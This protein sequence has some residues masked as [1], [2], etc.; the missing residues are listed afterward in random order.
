MPGRS[1]IALPVLSV[2]W[3]LIGAGAPVGGLASGTFTNPLLDG[4]ADPWVTYDRGY[5]YYT[6]TMGDRLQIWKTKDITQLRSAVTKVVWRAPATGPNSASIWAPELHHLGGKWYLYF[7]GADRAHDDD[8]HRHQFVLENSATDPL[9]GRWVE[10]G[11]LV[12]AHTGIDGTVFSDHGQLYFVYSAYIGPNSDLIIA[13]MLN[14][15][16]LSKTQIDIAQ[17]TFAWEEQGGR[18]ILEGPEF[19]PGRHGQRIL[20]Y[21]ASA[22]WSDDYS[23]GMLIAAP[24]K[25]LL[26]AASWKKTSEPVFKASPQNGVYAPGHNGLFK[27]PDGREDWIIY[28]ANSGPGQ[29]CDSRRAPRIQ[30]FTWRDDGLP[31][32]GVPVATGAPLLAPS[33][34]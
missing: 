4:G 12:T 28:H 2:V 7:T 9:S 20:L 31:D 13:R 10:R 19:L 8:D 26:D 25:N 30:K 6:N 32:F 5:Y 14:P 18:Q 15:W 11:M 16:T 34:R 1:K 21:S 23:I 27:S 17:P 29:R 24:G 22:C 3:A 33:G